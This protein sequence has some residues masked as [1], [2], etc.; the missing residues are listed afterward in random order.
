MSLT[1]HETQVIAYYTSYVSPL[2][3]VTTLGAGLTLR[4]SRLP[5]RIEKSTRVDSGNQGVSHTNI[6]WK[7]IHD[8]KKKNV[9]PFFAN[10]FPNLF[11]PHSG[12]VRKGGWCDD[13][14][15]DHSIFHQTLPFFP[16]LLLILLTFVSVCELSLRGGGGGG[17]Y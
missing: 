8:L 15:R 9:F 17:S 11:V 1:C 5:E 7:L 2:Q 13:L 4:D 3:W 14:T 6:L 10:P 16:V 12:V